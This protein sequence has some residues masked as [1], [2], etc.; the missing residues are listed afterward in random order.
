MACQG[1][2]ATGPISMRRMNLSGPWPW[3]LA[4]PLREAVAADPGIIGA[5][6]WLHADSI[7]DGGIAVKDDSWSGKEGGRFSAALASDYPSAVAGS[8]DKKAAVRKAP[9]RNKSQVKKTTKRY[10]YA[11]YAKKPQRRVT[12]RARDRGI[13]PVEGS[14]ASSLPDQKS[15]PQNPLR[16]LL[17]QG[18]GAQGV[19][20]E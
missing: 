5:K 16:A 9:V 3:L 7:W 17:R 8:E 2:A 11:N 1:N 13:Q 18:F 19:R 10:S 14:S 15:D 4:C 6:S 20:G 12:S